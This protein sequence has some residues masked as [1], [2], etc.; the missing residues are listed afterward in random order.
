[1]IDLRSDTV[2]VPSDAMREAAADADVG[3]DVY[4][5]DPTINALE[6]RAAETVGMEEALFV[7]SGTMGNQVAAMTHTTPGQSIVVEQGSHIYG[8]ECGGLAVH[9]GLQAT[10]IDGG[11]DGLYSP[12][13]LAAAIVEPTG[14]RAE[15]GLVAVENTHNRAGGVA[16]HPDAIHELAEVAD[17]AD[18]PLHLDGAR[19]FNAAVAL[20]IDPAEVADPAD[21]VMFCLS[22]GLGAPVG[23]ILAGNRSFIEDAR[24]YRRRL[25]G[26]MRQA[27]IIAAPGLLALEDWERLEADH[28]RADTLATG[29]RDIEGLSVPEPD[30][31]IVLVD[32]GDISL[33]PERFVERCEDHDILGFPFGSERVRLCTHWDI[34]DADIEVAIDAIEQVVA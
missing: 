12:E 9:A 15:T 5:E 22:K 25:G 23:S 20:D 30:S 18:I 29:L 21:S 14:H 31:N 2:T 26:G 7:P 3:D 8:W 28:R 34:T 6:R 19:L 27:G 11:P 13:Q 1:M 10:P 17:D 24:G 16:H 4:G 32:L 33:S